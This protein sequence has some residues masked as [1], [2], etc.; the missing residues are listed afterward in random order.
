MIWFE[1]E[2]LVDLYSWLV[3]VTFEMNELLKLFLFDSEWWNWAELCIFFCISRLGENKMKKKW[4]SR[5]FSRSSE[6]WDEILG[7][8]G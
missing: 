7:A 4:C 6:T 5:V 8:L 1:Y 2:N 3:Q